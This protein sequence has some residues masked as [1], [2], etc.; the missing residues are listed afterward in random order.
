MCYPSGKTLFLLEEE[1]WTLPNAK[2]NTEHE[3]RGREVE[4]KNVNANCTYITYHLQSNWN[5]PKGNWY[6][7][8]DMY[9]RRKHK[10]QQRCQLRVNIFPIKS[11]HLILTSPWQLSKSYN[12]ENNNLLLFL[13]PHQ[14]SLLI[15]PTRAEIKLDTGTKLKRS[16]RQSCKVHKGL[17]S[18]FLSTDSLTFKKRSLKHMAWINHNNMSHALHVC[19]S[20]T[21]SRIDLLRDNILVAPKSS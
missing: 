9:R 16:C 11:R 14:I 13:E 7:L 5:T 15:C 20:T 6:K 21:S 8:K 4:L 12:R 3:P 17:F 10:C 1:T 18:G 2:P 19:C